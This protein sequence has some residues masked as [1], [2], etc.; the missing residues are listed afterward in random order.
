[1]NHNVLED[2]ISW[3]NDNGVENRSNK[4]RFE[5]SSREKAVKIVYQAMHQDE[6]LTVKEISELLGVHEIT[7]GTW[8]VRETVKFHKEN[9]KMKNS[10]IKIRDLCDQLLHDLDQ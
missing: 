6:N 10:I 5:K 8:M 2:I 1:M 4:N 9:L 7:L 3:R